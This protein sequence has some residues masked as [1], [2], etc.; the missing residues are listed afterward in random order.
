M[1]NAVGLDEHVVAPARV[2]FTQFHSPD[3]P[4]MLAWSRFR[5]TLVAGPTRA[6]R[7]T[8]PAPSN[9]RQSVLWRLLATNNRE[10]GRSYL[11]YGRFEVAR[12]H[13]EK[14]QY[15]SAALTVEHIAGPSNGSRGWVIMAADT[16]VMTCSRWYNSMSTGSAAAEGALL[17]FR[18][19]TLADAPDVSGASGRFRRRSAVGADANTW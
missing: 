18:S 4:M 7:E 19:A 9:R 11:L 8:R 12:E 13:V 16:P 14:L 6:S 10:L 1:G 3:D 15:D 5:S 17:A 2:T